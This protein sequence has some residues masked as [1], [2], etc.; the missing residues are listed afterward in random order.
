MNVNIPLIQGPTLTNKYWVKLPPNLCYGLLDY[1]ECY[2]PEIAI[3]QQLGK[4]P[5]ILLILTPPLQE[6]QYAGHGV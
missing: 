5:C 4:H 1:I 3:Y 6:R 2:E